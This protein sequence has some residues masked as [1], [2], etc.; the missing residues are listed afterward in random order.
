LPF[1]NAEQHLR[2]I[3]ESINNIDT[4]L[5]DMDFDV[6]RGD[7]RTKSA[8]ERQMQIITEAAVRLGE[9]GDRLCPGV[10]WKGFRGMGNV[11]RHGYHR[12]DDKIVWDTVK[13]ELPPV[14]AA[15]LRAL[16]PPPASPKSPTAG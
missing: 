5:G 16:N 8:V 4:F 11:L 9:D 15:V 10:D 14:K 6:Y 7:L 1:K 13:D 12:I 2:D 3:L